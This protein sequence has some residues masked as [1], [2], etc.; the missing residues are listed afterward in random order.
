MGK[1]A[2][3]FSGQGSQ[4]AG[5]GKDFYE[6]NSSVRTLFDEAE[7]YREGTLEQCFDGNTEILR[8]TENAQPCLYL[9]DLAAAMALKESHVIPDAVAGFS[10]GEIPSLAFAGAFSYIDGF[11]IA[12]RRGELMADA[13]NAVKTSMIAVLKLD[14]KVVE[15]ICKKYSHVYP[16]NYNC[17]G[18]LVVSGL[19]EELEKFKYDI[20]AIG[21]TIIPLAVSGGFHSPFMDTAAKEF[22]MFLSGIKIDI[23][24]ISA[25]S[26]YTAS[27]YSGNIKNFMENQINHPVKWE[28]IIL[29]MVSNGFDTFIETGVGNVLQ[30]LILKIAP[31][32]KSFSVQNNADIFLVLKE[33]A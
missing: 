6:N 27:P 15:D 2:F 21:G 32:V 10:L 3:V 9:S 17:R 23:P 19:T 28:K 7:K 25:Y 13:A 33:I 1:I 16:V 14:N 20:K 29:Q 30:K 31:D 26:N 8:Q 24:I 5:M 18:Q 11:K 12:C 22:G 4:H